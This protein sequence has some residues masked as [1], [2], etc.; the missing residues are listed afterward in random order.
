MVR[1][2]FKGKPTRIRSGRLFDVVNTV[3][4]LLVVLII[5]YPLYFTIIASFSEPYAL[6]RGEVI[7]LPV[8]FTMEAYTNVLK[9][10]EIWLGYLNT[11]FYA[12][13]GTLY[14]LAVTIPTAYVMARKQ[15][16]GKNLWMAYFMF[17]MYFSGGMIPGYILIKNLQ[18]LNTRWALILP[19]GMSVYNM[20]I[21]RTFY[22]SNIPDEL[23]EA[24]KIDGANEYRIFFN[25]ALP[26]SGSIIAVLALYILVGQWNSYFPALLYLTEDSMYPLQL[27]LRNILLFNQ[28]FSVIETSSMS[29][30]QLEAMMRRQMM[31]ETMKYALIFI[32]SL[33]VLIAY[34]FVQKHF[35]KGVMIGAVKG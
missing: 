8:G 17:T 10:S 29:S 26:L 34:P 28:Q 3:L 32:S 13:I 31:A 14:G 9:N 24:A 18:L 33:P 35:V 20:I 12:A 1:E 2:D 19:A 4:L 15:L 21:G 5:I 23:Y 27:V 16:K 7:A 11:F 22:Q 25:I 6:M 30:A